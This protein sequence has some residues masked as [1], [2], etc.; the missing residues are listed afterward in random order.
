MGAVEFCSSTNAEAL[1]GAPGKIIVGVK[2]IVAGSPVAVLE[3]VDE[4]IEL[5]AAELLL[6]ATELLLGT[7]ELAT[8]D[9]LLVRDEFEPALDV[10]VDDGADDESALLLDRLPYA[11]GNNGFPWSEFFCVNIQL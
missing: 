8:D 2:R 11:I 6:D 9:V 3:F 1:P 5:G 4:A 10:G 7:L